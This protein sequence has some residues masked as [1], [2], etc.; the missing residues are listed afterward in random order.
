MRILIAC[1]AIA[2]CSCVVMQGLE[3]DHDLKA[4]DDVCLAALATPSLDPIRDKVTL[5]RSVNDGP[6]PASLTNNT[7]LPMDDELRAIS[8]WRTLRS[9]CE[10][11]QDAAFHVPD[12]ASPRLSEHLNYEVS[13][14]RSVRNAVD[15]YIALL[16][17]RKV[18]Y[19]E[20]EQRHYEL[21]HAGGEMQKQLQRGF[22]HHDVAEEDAAKSRITTL[23]EEWDA[24]LESVANRKFAAS[25]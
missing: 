19:G 18:T 25:Q 10:R 24:Y 8:E 11:C 9:D 23:F 20:F 16:A 13:G 12:S 17:E 6:P 1:L 3:L 21:V 2:L 7:S 22:R 15:R 4:A 14:F 5:F